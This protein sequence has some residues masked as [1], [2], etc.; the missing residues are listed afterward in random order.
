MNESNNQCPPHHVPTPTTT[1]DGTDDNKLMERL[2]NGDD[3]ALNSII[4]KYGKEI[5]NLHLR[6]TCHVDDANDLAQ[7]TFINVYISRRKFSSKFRFKSWLYSIAMN[8]LRNHYRWEKRHRT[9]PIENYFNNEMILED[10]VHSPKNNP[11]RESQ[12]RELGSAIESAVNSLKEDQKEV[13]ILCE[14]QDL[15]IEEAAKALKT[16]AKA[17][18]LRLYRARKVLREKLKPYLD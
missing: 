13:I 2:L 9:K 11:S 10:C 12:I 6:Y 4:S 1:T 5:Y 18:E 3:S 16:T 7:Q 17:V 14:L 15:T 8:L